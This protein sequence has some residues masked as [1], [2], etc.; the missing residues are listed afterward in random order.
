MYK[1][2]IPQLIGTEREIAKPKTGN[3]E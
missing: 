2:V 1:A 3:L